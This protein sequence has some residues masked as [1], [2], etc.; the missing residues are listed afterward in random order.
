MWYGEGAMMRSPDDVAVLALAL[1]SVPVSSVGPLD[2]AFV[3]WQ[4]A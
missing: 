2:D 3:S 4:S 1:G